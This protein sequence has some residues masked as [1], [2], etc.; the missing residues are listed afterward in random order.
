MSREVA[1]LSAKGVSAGL[2]V[3]LVG[4]DPA[5]RSYVNNKQKDCN[6]VGIRSFEY[7]LPEDTQ[8]KDLLE[9]ID[10]LNEDPS[11]DGI[12]VQLPIPRHLDEAKVIRELRPQRMWTPSIR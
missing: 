7:T 10:T 9:L 4:N 2:A 5:S 1:A 12:L 3:I 8:E 11:V 6:E